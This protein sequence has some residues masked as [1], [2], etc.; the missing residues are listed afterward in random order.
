MDRQYNNE[1]TPELL[2]AMDHSPFTA[3]EPAEMDEGSRALIVEQEAFC[4]EHP[5]TAIYRLATA[6]CR[7]RWGGIGNEHNPEQGEGFKIRL[8]N[9]QWASVLTEGC[10]ITYPDSSTAKIISSAGSEYRLEDK[11]I[12]LVGSLLDNGDEIISTP[13][14]GSV[15]TGREGVA[16]PSDFLVAV[17]DT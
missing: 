12:A 14:D 5:I 1:L 10:I 13:Q 7:T 3:E 6:G 8:E 11:G 4:R 9:G 2:A 17:G 16:M 15:L